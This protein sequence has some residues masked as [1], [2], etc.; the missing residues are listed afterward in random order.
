VRPRG[1]GPRILIGAVFDATGKV[2]GTVCSR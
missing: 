1:G 2:I